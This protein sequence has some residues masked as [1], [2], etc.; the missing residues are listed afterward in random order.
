MALI[1]ADRVKESS[2][3]TGTGN[4]S[5][6]GASTGFRSFSNGVGVGNTCYYV[7]TEGP[8]FEIGLGTLN[9]TATLARTVVLVSSSANA[10]VNWGSGS[11]DVF[12][13]YPGVKAVILDN[14]NELNLA[15]A[16]TVAGA[17]S[18]ATTLSV[19][20]N[21]SVGGTLKVTDE[22][23]LEDVSASGTFDVSGNMSGGGTFNLGGSASIASTLSVT[24][25]QY[26]SAELTVRGA[27]SGA[28]TLN[29]GG[30][31]SGASTLNVK[32]EVSVASTLSVTGAQFNS[33][34]FTI[35]GAISGAST[36]NV[37]G[38]ISGAG[39][40]DV[41]G[42]VSVGGTLGIV[43]NQLNSANITSQGDFSAKGSLGVGGTATFDSAIIGK[44]TLDIAGNASVQGTL[45]IKGAASAISTLTA[46]GGVSDG[47]GNLRDVP[48]ARSLANS[49]NLASTDIGN[50]VLN[51]SADNTFGVPN[52]VFGTGQ[53]VS[54]V[55]K[56]GSCTIVSQVGTS[57]FI[58]AGAASA[59][60]TAILADHGVC[61]LL[62]VGQNSAFITGNVS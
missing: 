34:T 23:N 44:S 16:L 55:N 61:S 38:A 37:G 12:T 36:L 2:S 20:G 46:T 60:S 10:A 49:A 48:Q 62:F 26:N 19:K 18:G 6:S 45:S 3:T 47:D 31:I 4:F 1:Q 56:A 30:A 24:G 13:T 17:M 50:F 8:T 40:L 5:L 41:K 35:R 27:I 29:I 7:I 53:I 25:N 21:A 33:S 57:G 22:S 52:G 28:S 14:N 11:K 39:T 51:T 59:T 58:L 43:G 32:G 54:I 15:S 9:A 42:N